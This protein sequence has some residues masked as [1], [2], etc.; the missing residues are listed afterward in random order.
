M[1]SLVKSLQGITFTVISALSHCLVYMFWHVWCR[2]LDRSTAGVI[3]VWGAVLDL[4]WL[5]IYV[6]RALPH[7]TMVK[8]MNHSGSTD[9]EGSAH[10]HKIT[11]NT[12]KTFLF[13][14]WPTVPSPCR[15]YKKLN[16]CAYYSP[17]FRQPR[18]VSV[19]PSWP[20]SLRQQFVDKV[21][22]HFR[23]L[24]YSQYCPVPLLANSPLS[25]QPLW[26]VECLCIF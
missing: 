24:E 18:L 13:L 6:H 9:S 21:W 19:G 20:L 25:L 22:M 12:L 26:K 15:P 10:V 23:R 11:E 2:L 14:S 5:D 1:Y 8:G 7:P 4:P 17:K 3:L 16:A